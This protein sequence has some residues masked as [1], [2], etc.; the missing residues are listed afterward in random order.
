ME[1]QIHNQQKDEKILQQKDISSKYVVLVN[2]NDEY[3]DIEEKH[4]AHNSMTKLH[5][6][7]SAFLFNE[8][9]KLLLQKR[10]NSKKTWPDFWSNSVCGHPQYMEDYEDA[11]KRCARFELGIENII[12]LSKISDYRYRFEF[13]GIVENEIC[14]IYVAKFYGELKINPSE[15]QSTKLLSWDEFIVELDQNKN[16]FTPWCIDET[17]IIQTKIQNKMPCD[18]FKTPNATTKNTS[19]IILH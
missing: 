9:G 13:N 5:R 17:K 11:V 14:P 6:G 12:D 8:E 4:S 2:E 19:S 1:H 16:E 15:V 3:I 10:D 7:F 18:I